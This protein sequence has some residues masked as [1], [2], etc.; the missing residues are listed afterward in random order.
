MLPSA[1][2]L[3]SRSWNL[4]SRRLWTLITI[5]LFSML[6]LLG[7]NILS[8]VLGGPRQY[9]PG[10]PV[11]NGVIAL[12]FTLAGILIPLWQTAA[13]ISAIQHANEKQGPMAS[14]ARSF[15]RLGPYLLVS[16]L[17]SLVI[18]GGLILLIVP[19]IYL[20]VSLSFAPLVVMTENQGFSS[21][22]KSLGYVKGLWWRTF[23]RYLLLFG[24]GLVIFF[25]I[26]LPL[27]IGAILNQALFA[28]LGGL[29]TLASGFV[30]S[31]FFTV[32]W[33]LLYEDI[34]KV[35]SPAESV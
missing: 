16:F 21:L 30:I 26:L 8:S 2:S 19:G 13:A 14:Y 23:G 24:L 27:V 33:C 15:K 22:G 20:A 32:Y 7:I 31:P 35:K 11:L 28:I 5:A 10:N 6:A 12:L 25:L 29:I 18:L 17:M 3:I 34:K 9:V 4:F 1:G